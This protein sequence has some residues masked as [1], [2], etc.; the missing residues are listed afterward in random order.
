MAPLWYPV[1]VRV[2]VGLRTHACKLR[3]LARDYRQIT[4]TA[5]THAQTHTDVGYYVGWCC[6]RTT[7]ALRERIPFQINAN[8][9]PKTNAAVLESAEYV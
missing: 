6:A 7:D 9:A 3:L 2:C 5:N 4:D 8:T 1:C